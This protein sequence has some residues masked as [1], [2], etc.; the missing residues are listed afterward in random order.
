MKKL[1]VIALALFTINGVAQEKRKQKADRKGSELRKEMTPNEIADLKAKHLTLK[2]DLTDAQ[3]KKVHAVVLKQAKAGEENRKNRKVA[4]D[5]EKVKP[6][7]EE[8]L[9]MQN[10]RLDQQIEMKREMKTILTEEQYA[11]FEKMKS[12]KRGEKGKRGEKRRHKKS[13]K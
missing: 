7:K 12:R 11:K 8:R 2:L 4:Y 5:E 13:D 3:Q 6:T 9:K 1:L 10:F